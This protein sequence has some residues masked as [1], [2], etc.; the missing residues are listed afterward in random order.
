MKKRPAIFGGCLSDDGDR[1]IS[2]F[3]EFCAGMD[4]ER[5]L[6]GA[7]ASLRFGTEIRTIGFDQ[8]A[9]Q[10]GDAGGIPY[11]IG[12]FEGEG[13]GKGEK[14]APIK[15]L[16]GIRG[17]ASKAVKEDPPFGL[18]PFIEDSQA[19]VEG[20]AAMDDDRPANKLCQIE[21]TAKD[22][23]LNL[24]RG[25][26]IMIIKTCFANGT[27]C[28]AFTELLEGGK[29]IRGE[30]DG[31]MGMNADGGEHPGSGYGKL[32]GLQSIGEGG[33]DGDP[34]GNAGLT[35]AGED[36]VHLAFIAFFCQMRVRINPF[37]DVTP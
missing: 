13:T 9:V 31:F 24:F 6:V 7:N 2:Q 21:H 29:A 11:G 16:T 17:I 26:L 30:L 27:N 4:K 3:G 12:F 19:V 36:F 18:S 5:R 37:H 32:N 34:A 33:A 15:D 1:L 10:G 22:F 28:F 35:G 20:F 14:T 8:N 25:K 23:L